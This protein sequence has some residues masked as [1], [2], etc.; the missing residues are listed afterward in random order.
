M[1]DSI[2]TSPSRLVKDAEARLR[3]ALDSVG[4]GSWDWNIETGEVF[5]SDRWIGSLGYGRSDVPPYIRF[6]E[7]LLHPEDTE[8][9][10]DALNEH[11]DGRTE[12]FESEY[13]ITRNSGQYRWSLDRGRVLERNEA[14]RAI[15]MAGTRFDITSRKR[16]ESV[17]RQ[18]E[19]LFC[20]IAETA[21]RN[22]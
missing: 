17:L 10:W 8:R 13:R 2:S 21:V 1:P 16:A 3:A 6:W 11:F 7:S 4:D 15:R 9:V 5:Y 20:A 19:A 12:H 18:T 14:G 22:S